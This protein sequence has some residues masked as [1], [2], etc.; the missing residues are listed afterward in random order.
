[1]PLN[2]ADAL[3]VLEE[4]YKPEM[5]KMLQEQRFLWGNVRDP[6]YWGESRRAARGWPPMALLP[7]AALVEG[8]VAKQRKAVRDLRWRVRNTI[9]AARAAWDGVDEW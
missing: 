2:F 6:N 8:W 3:R 4:E 5:E 9:G 1:M 7:R